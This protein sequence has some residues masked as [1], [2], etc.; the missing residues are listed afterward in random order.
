[1]PPEVDRFHL[2]ASYALSHKIV[3]AKFRKFW[4]SLDDS[5]RDMI[6]R[7]VGDYFK[8]ANFVEGEPRPIAPASS[9]PR[10]KKP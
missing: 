8:L 4:R 6:A 1:M 9:F 2:A 10:I 3:N 5:D 7:N